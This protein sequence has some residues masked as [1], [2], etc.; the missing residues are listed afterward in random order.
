MSAS[1][2]AVASLARGLTDN[3]A[4]QLFEGLRIGRLSRDSSVSSIEE[5]TGVRGKV[6]REVWSLIQRW[7]E[8]PESLA[9]CLM[10]AAQVRRQ[11]A[12]EIDRVELVWTGPVQFTVSTRTTLST[13]KEMIEAAQRQITV[14]GYRVTEGARTVFDSLA[15]KRS[16]GVSVRIML[17]EASVQAATLQSLWPAET[18]PPEV[19]ENKTRIHAKLL[20]IDSSDALVTSANLTRFGLESNIEFGLRVRGTTALKIENLLEGLLKAGHFRRIGL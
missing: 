6:S 3:Q 18:E 9:V 11:L 2:A 20:V 1:A 7:N 14:V 19:Y 5:L 15:E 17:D 12:D 10:T 16:L 13:A 4:A 8:T